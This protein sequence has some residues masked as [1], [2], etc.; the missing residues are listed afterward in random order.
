MVKQLVKEKKKSNINLTPNT[1]TQ[2]VRKEKEIKYI[3][4]TKDKKKK[5]HTATKK[6]V[7]GKFSCKRLI[8]SSAFFC[9]KVLQIKFF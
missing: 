5:K 4:K 8:Y 7:G 1:L 9:D 2:G 3:R 6:K